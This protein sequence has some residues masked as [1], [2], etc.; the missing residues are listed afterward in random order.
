MARTEDAPIPI[1]PA[2]YE[3]LKAELAELKERR[4]SMVDRV[5]SARSDGDL[6]ENFAYHDARH[7]L[8][9]LDGRVETIEG[10]LHGAVVVDEVRGDGAIGVGS[11]VVVKDEFGE[12][13][14]TLVGPAE[15]DLARGLISLSSPMGAALM[16]GRV[17]ETI[18]FNTPGGDRSATIV[19]I[20]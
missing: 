7:D 3:A 14:Y 9:M 16:G 10:L 4:P 13:T 1:T 6:K 5:A 18:T 8:G 17:G 2:G 20:G 19:G 11:K 12:S 15:V